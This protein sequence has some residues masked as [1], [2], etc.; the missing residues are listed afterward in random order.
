M[1]FRLQHLAGVGDS[2]SGQRRTHVSGA[3]MTQ[4]LDVPDEAAQQ[5]PGRKPEVSHGVHRAR[6]RAA[7][8]H[9]GDEER[10]DHRHAAALDRERGHRHVERPCSRAVVLLVNLPIAFL[11]PSSS[12]HAALVMPILAPLADF[13]GV[14]RSIAVTAYQ[15]ASGLVNLITPTSAVI[16]GG[17]ALSQASAT[18]ATCASSCPSSA[19]ALVDQ[20]RVRRHR[21]RA[22]AERGTPCRSASI[23]RSGRLRK[24][25]VHRPGLEQRRLTP[26]N[27]ADLLFDDV[28][29]VRKAKVEHAAF[30]A[31]DARSAASRSSTPRTC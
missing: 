29:W 30:V 2:T 26:E 25:I 7:R 16:M 14:P 13:A 6:G 12:G 21:R 17:L 5:K 3:E 10:A 22:L 20:P 8:G 23:P 1:P 28:I 27:A 9:G 15:S 4:V 19:I 11:V 24:V 31:G 18:T